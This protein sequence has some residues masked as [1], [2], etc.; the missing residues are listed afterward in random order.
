MC[1]AWRIEFCS[2][3]L[4]RKHP[5]AIRWFH[6]LNFP[7]LA[8]MVWSGILIYWANDT[9]RLGWG[10]ITLLRFFPQGFYEAVGV[11]QRGADGQLHGRLAEGMAWHFLFMWFFAV[12]GALYFLYTLVSGQWRHLLPN[13]RSLAEAWQ[14]LLHDLRLSKQAPPPSKYNG[15]QRI[16][17]TVVVIMGLGSMLT[18][19][20]IYKPVQLAWLTAVFGGYQFARVLHFALT[21]GYVL[22]FLIHVMQVLRA[23]WNNFRGMLTG[24]T[25]EGDA[26]DAA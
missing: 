7:L 12:N 10:D 2:M 16:A 4:V 20:A 6:W 1:G 22:F 26:K 11:V 15:A 23:G 21:I 8:M 24:H 25:L 5:L 9:Y 14:V 18:G 19:L 3:R 17:Y 13:R